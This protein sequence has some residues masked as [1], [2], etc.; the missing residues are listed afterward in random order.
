MALDATDSSEL[1][2][3]GCAAGGGKEGCGGEGG[4]SGVGG[5]EGGCGSVAV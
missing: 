2:G 3:E 5:G 4:E 1:W